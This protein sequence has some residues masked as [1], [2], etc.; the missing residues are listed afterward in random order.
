MSMI[1]LGQR[2][3]A[4]SRQLARATTEQKNAALDRTGRSIDGATARR[5][6]PPTPSMLR[7]RKRTAC[8]PR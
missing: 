5:F 6:W 8:P 4:A 2:A 3:K 7:Q 1:E